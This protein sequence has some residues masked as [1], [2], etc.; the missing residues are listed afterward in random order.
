MCHFAPELYDS[1]DEL[2]ERGMHEFT[3]IY[4]TTVAHIPRDMSPKGRK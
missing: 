3:R 4:Q 2:P 1:A